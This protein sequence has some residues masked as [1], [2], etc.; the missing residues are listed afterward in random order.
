MSPVVEQCANIR[1]EIGHVDGVI[2]E[3]IYLIE[4]AENQEAILGL[5]SLLDELH[6]VQET[7]TNIQELNRW[8]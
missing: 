2:G 6:Q 5:H 1:R 7:I 8:I 4:D 3:L